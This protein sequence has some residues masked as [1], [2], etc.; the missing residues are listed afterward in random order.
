MDAAYKLGAGRYIQ[1]PGALTEAGNEICRYGKCVW[2]VGGPTALSLTKESLKKQFQEKGIMYEFLEYSGY[3]TQTITECYAEYVRKHKFEIVVGVGGGRIMDLAKAIAHI[4]RLPVITIPTCSAT[5]AAY[6]PMSVMYEADGA[7]IGTDGGN[8]YHDYEVAGV[9]VDEDIM[10]HQP[11][12]YAAAGMLDSMA[13]AI[14]IQNGCPGVDMEKSGFEIYTAY[15]LSKYIYRILEEGCSDIYRDIEQHILSKRVHNYLYINF[16]LTGFI[17]GSSKALGQTALAHEMYYAV[18]KYFTQESKK[19]LHGEIVG[20]SL[21]LQLCYNRQEEQIP[22]FIEF[23]RTMNMPV[24]LQELGIPETNENIKK[25]YCHLKNTEFVDKSPENLEQLKK[26]V[27][28]M[29][30]R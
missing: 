27:F 28:S 14:E 22:G 18:R 4:A 25:I 21:I 3:T 19:Y 24:I 23:M 26:A 6:T 12:R 29:C 16:V 5:C 11:P 9:I 10:V 15:I 17:S 1:M 20:S 13:K 7:A 2:V 8:F 30:R